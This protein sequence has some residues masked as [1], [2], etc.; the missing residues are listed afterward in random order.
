MYRRKVYG[1]SQ[2]ASCPFC[3][4]VAVL[5]NSQDI[6][7]CKDH[8]DN[9]LNDLKC[10]CGEYLDLKFGKFGPFFTCI[11]CGAVTMKKALEYNDG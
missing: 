1:Y 7:V 8:K 10:L 6:P 5:K 9:E 2:E 11:K 3:G 4:D